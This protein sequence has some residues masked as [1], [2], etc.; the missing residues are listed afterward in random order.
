MANEAI[1]KK[2]KFIFGF[3]RFVQDPELK[4]I[5]EETENNMELF[6]L[7]D[8]DLF[9]VSAGADT[10]NSY[11]FGSCPNCGQNCKQYFAP[12]SPELLTCSNCSHQYSVPG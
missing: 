6:R 8:V 9:S 11:V 3:Q 1:E 5:I 7:S 4:E 2:L 10:E 12:G